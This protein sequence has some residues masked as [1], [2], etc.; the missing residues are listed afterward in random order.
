MTLE[1]YAKDGH[2]V[3]EERGYISFSP[4]FFG[5][6]P[7]QVRWTHPRVEIESVTVSERTPPC[8]T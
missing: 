6:I 3:I 1:I 4:Y 8:P 7:E 2:I 5:S